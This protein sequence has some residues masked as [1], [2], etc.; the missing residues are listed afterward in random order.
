M[1]VGDA[2]LEIYQDNNDVSSYLQPP[3]IPTA[4]PLRR[5]RSAA[6]VMRTITAASTIYPFQ[7]PPSPSSPVSET[8]QAPRDGQQMG[9]GSWFA[10]AQDSFLGALPLQHHESPSSLHSSTSHFSQE[11][12]SPSSRLTPNDIDCI[13]DVATPR[14]SPRSLRKDR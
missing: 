3:T 1:R 4:A 10:A 14:L 2:L 6:A 8:I 9:G 11:P 7:D 13:V 12:S 5:V